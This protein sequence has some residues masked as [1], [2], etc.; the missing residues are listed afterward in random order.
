MQGPAGVN[1]QQ[2]RTAADTEHGQPAPRRQLEHAELELVA[3][4]IDIA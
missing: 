4:R 3:Q 1:V 2:L